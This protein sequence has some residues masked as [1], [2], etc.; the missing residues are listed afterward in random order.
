V[1]AEVDLPPA[2]R[3]Q[4][5][6]ALI[7]HLAV[8][9]GIDLLHIKG[10]AAQRGL[11]AEGRVSTDV[12][13]IVRPSHASRLAEALLADGWEAVT[14]FKSGSV[15]HHAMT[16]W[17]E[18][19]GHVDIHRSFPGIGLEP[20]AF[21]NL[22]WAARTSTRIADWPCRVPSPKHQALLIVLHG[23]RDPHRG[24]SDVDFIRNT[25]GQD[26]WERLEL[27]AAHL[28]A[29]VS[30]AAATGRLS[31]WHGHPDHDIWEVVS[32]GGTRVELFR[33]RWRA[34]RS[35]RQRRDLVRT[36]LLINRDHLRMK[37]LRE[38]RARDYAGELWQ[39]AREVAQF[40][41]AGRS[42]G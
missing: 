35:L 15:F 29:S 33:A 19:W 40:L 25:L 11:Y 24:A 39:R 5:A 4:L 34:S 22:L 31:E 17:N 8:S 9:S 32:R 16:L 3:I 20:E 26:E 38:P 14:S 28:G 10:Y 18:L 21:F 30:L 2:D 36:L 6:H 27:L 1:I 13:L 23:A 37:I 7:E 42:T 41:G 12:D